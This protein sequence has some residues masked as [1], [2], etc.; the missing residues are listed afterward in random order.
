MQKGKALGIEDMEHEMKEYQIGT[1]FFQ[2]LSG[3]SVNISDLFID[4]RECTVFTD[5]TLTKKL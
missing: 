2:I 1:T 3:Q 4:C 5:K